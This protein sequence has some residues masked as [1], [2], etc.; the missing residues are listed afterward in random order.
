MSRNLDESVRCD[1]CGRSSLLW[2]CMRF[3]PYDDMDPGFIACLFC[4][5]SFNTIVAYTK[6]ACEVQAHVEWVHD[7]HTEA[8][9]SSAP[10]HPHATS[11]GN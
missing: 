3:T 9:P 2:N 8:M 4:V 5:R 10:Y 7:G 1:V 11:V 6:S